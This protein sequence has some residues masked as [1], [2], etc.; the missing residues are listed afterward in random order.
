MRIFCD[1][2]VLVAGCVRQHPHFSRAHPVLSGV[3]ART[4]E[5]YVS[6]YSLAETYST[7]TS[8]PLAPRIAPAEAQL[9]IRLNI[10]AHFQ[11]V[12]VDLGMHE[13]A[14]AACEQRGLIGGAVYDALLIECARTVGCER[15]F[16]F[17]LRDYQRLAPDLADQIAAP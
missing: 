14:L 10:R 11:L 8:L 7:L 17:N 13:R 9:M 6:C 3:V 4:A 1:T 15:I 2:S 16:T 12:P 5:G